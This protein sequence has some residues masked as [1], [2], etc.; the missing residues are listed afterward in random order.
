LPNAKV[1]IHAPNTWSKELKTDESGVIRFKTP[2]PGQYVAE[3]I[4]L[5]KS[6]GEFGSAPYEAIRHRATFTWNVNE[7]SPA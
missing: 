4:H 5:E 1:N 3:V 2:W 6:P 7:G